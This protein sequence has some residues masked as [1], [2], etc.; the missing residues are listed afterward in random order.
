MS[1]ELELP[2]TLSGYAEGQTRLLLQGNSIREAMS[3]L[4]SRFGDLAARLLNERGE[5]FSFWI[6]FH[7]QDRV[8]VAQWDEMALC[9]GDHLEVVAL[10]SGG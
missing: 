2:S 6:M 3:D 8:D 7:N 5:L 9:N 1:V 4:A 10:A